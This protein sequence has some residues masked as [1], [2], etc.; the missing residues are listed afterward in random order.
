MIKTEDFVDAVQG[1]LFDELPDALYYKDFLPQEFERPAV[2]VGF[3]EFKKME[4]L[5][6]T[7]VS[8]EAR[9]EV[10]YFAER[11]EHSRPDRMGIYDV[12]DRFREAFSGGKI[13]VCGMEFDMDFMPAGYADRTAIADIKIEF[14]DDVQPGNV[15]NENAEMMNEINLRM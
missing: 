7:I 14:M 10:I 2:F 1:V 13:T 12:L 8:G 15:E 9:L 11:N 5:T 3:R 4:H 6:S